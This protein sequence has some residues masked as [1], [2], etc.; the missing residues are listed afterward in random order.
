MKK[1]KG[2]SLVELIIV[3]AIM[4]ILVGVAVPVL[5]VYLNRAKANSDVNICD[6]I[7]SALTVAMN[8]PDVINST[9]NSWNQVNDIKSGNVVSLDNLTSSTFVDTVNEIM[10]YDVSSLNDSR[11]RFRTKLAKSGGVLKVQYYD[12]SFYVW[13]DGS[14]ASGRDATAY[15]VADASGINDDNVIYVK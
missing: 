10:G 13:I 3:I 15:T 7:Q 8:D 4:A 2:F 11:N 12:S 5:F 1:N 6:S 14:D 9:D